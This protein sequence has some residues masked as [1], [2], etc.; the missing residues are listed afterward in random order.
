MILTITMNPAI[1][2][3]YLVD[4]YQ[5]GEVHRPSKMIASAGGKGLNV[6]RVAKLLGEDVAAT[7]LLGGANGDYIKNKVEELSIES[8]FVNINGDTRICINVSD[9]VNQRSTEVLEVGPTI[10]EDE[11]K[12]FL[13][14]YEDM[15]KDVKVVT[16]SG[17]LPKGLPSDFY[18]LLVN[19]ANDQGKKVILDTSSAAFLEGIKALPYMVK[20][21]AEEIKDIYHEDVTTQ[22]GLIEAIKCFKQMGIEVPIIS[23]GK[24][25]C[26]AGL[27]DGI[28]RF[29]NPSVNVVNTV[30]S[31][32]SFVAGC[33]V[34][35]SRGLSQ[36]DMVKMGIACGT[37]NT[38]FSQT[39]YVEQ[40]MVNQYFNQVEVIKLDNYNT[41]NGV[42]SILPM[43]VN[44]NI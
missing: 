36:V 32:D 13:K 12:T 7:G 29:T 28:Y 6:A 24:E 35:I 44:K 21:N 16:L 5:L 30:G 2:K 27:E 4:N 22:Q 26:I 10:S 9:P 37:T 31:G 8:R 20:P 17:S 19:I 11:A 15:V 34:G 40:E 18:T 3:I 41:G 33:A 42:K 23:L 39:G 43:P 1:D 25:G 14:A 38:L